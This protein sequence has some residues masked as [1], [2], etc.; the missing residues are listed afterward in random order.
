MIE[1]ENKAGAV[2]ERM[3]VRARNGERVMSR[4]F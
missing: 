2:A 1:D 4:P 3:R